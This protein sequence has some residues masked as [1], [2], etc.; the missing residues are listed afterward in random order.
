M[1]FT[2]K[3]GLARVT[4]F[5]VSLACASGFVTRQEIV[6]A[7]EPGDDGALILTR[8]PSDENVLHD[9]SRFFESE[10][11]D[12]IATGTPA[13]VGIRASGTTAHGSYLG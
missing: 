2:V 7:N 12:V 4:C 5:V 8:P 9:V 11:G 6:S 10:P 13:G 3:C 1:P